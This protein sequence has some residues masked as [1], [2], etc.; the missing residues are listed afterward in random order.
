MLSLKNNVGDVIYVGKAK[1]FDF[2][3]APT[4]EFLRDTSIDRAD[5]IEDIL[6]EL[7][8]S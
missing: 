4:I 2:R 8:G 5:E 3:K 6:G 7:K 1:N